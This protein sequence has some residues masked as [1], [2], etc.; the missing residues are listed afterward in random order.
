MLYTMKEACELTGMTYQGLKFYCNEGL[1]PNVKRGKNN[2]RIFDE[3]DIAWVKSLLCLRDC[4]M[5]IA[6]MKE[7][8]KLCL[9]G[10]ESIPDRKII[11]ERRK[12]MLTKQIDALKKSV[13][14]ID[15][16][17]KF[18]DEVLS[19]EREYFSNLLPCSCENS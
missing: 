16:K 2:H 13:Q 1:V 18:Y 5:G 11:L 10:K 6:D 4:G 8:M 14:Y 19:G 15:Y 12:A 9:L 3:R 7:Y 17:Q